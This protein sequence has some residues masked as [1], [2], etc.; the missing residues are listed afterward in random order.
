[1]GKNII[2]PVQS[3]REG[4]NLKLTVKV[5]KL[6]ENRMRARAELLGMTLEEFVQ[7]QL[8]MA[9]G[10][11]DESI[12]DEGKIVAA[13]PIKRKHLKQDMIK[14]ELTAEGRKKYY[15]CPHCHNP[16]YK[17]Q[18][19][20]G[21]LDTTGLTTLYHY[22]L[23][24]ESE[25]VAEYFKPLHLSPSSVLG[26]IGTS[27]KTLEPRKRVFGLNYYVPKQLDEVILPVLDRVT[28]KVEELQRIT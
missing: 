10:W 13:R 20:Y 18:E 24:H 28:E 21:G 14:T 15:Q 23:E 27:A 2:Y 12:N 5:S 16:V 9:S 3:G 17:K 25:A 26:L 11:E 19:D 22:L 7:K 8:T 6:M 4:D 1:M